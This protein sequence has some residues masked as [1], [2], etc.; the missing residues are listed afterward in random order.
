MVAGYTNDTYNYWLNALSGVQ[1]GALIPIDTQ[2]VL[3]R[4]LNN[5]DFEPTIKTNKVKEELCL[6]S[7]HLR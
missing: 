6:C 7:K 2:N 4:D 5:S 1:A 3:Q